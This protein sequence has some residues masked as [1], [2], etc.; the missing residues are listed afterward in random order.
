MDLIGDES[1]VEGGR[2]AKRSVR[3]DQVQ[4]H[5]EGGVE[6]SSKP[7]DGQVDH[8]ARV[9]VANDESSVVEALVVAELGCHGAVSYEADC[10]VARASEDLR[11]RYQL[12]VEHGS[13][14]DDPVREDSA[15]GEQRR[16]V[17][18][19]SGRLCNCIGEPHTAFRENV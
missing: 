14:L 2:R 10:L 18:A 6:A 5:E 15:A 16:H 3:V 7:L 17:G 19:G 4:P 12:F 9:I 1:S 8:L 11:R 13:D